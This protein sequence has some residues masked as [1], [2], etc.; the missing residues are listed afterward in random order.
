MAEMAEMAELQ[1]ENA[2]LH[3]RLA[4]LEHLIA[5]RGPAEMAPHPSCAPALPLSAPP[6]PP[7]PETEALEQRIEER[8]ATLQQAMVQ[9][10]HELERREAVEWALRE[11]EERHRIIS[12]LISDYVYAGCRT[13]DG[14]LVLEWVSGAFERIT[15]YT[16]EEVN[17][18]GSWTTLL[19][20]DDLPRIAMVAQAI[21]EKRSC[22][23]EYRVN[24]RHCGIRWLR[25]Y[26]RPVPSIS[27][28][29]HYRI[30]GAVQDI[31][32]AKQTEEALRKARDAAETA[33]RLKSEFLANMSHEI[34]TPLNA[35]IG[36]TTL[37]FNTS[38]TDRQREFVE[39]IRTGGN[40]LLVIINNILDY[41]KIEAGKLELDRQPLNLRACLEE[42]LDLIAAGAAE[43]G[44][45]LTLMIAPHIPPIIM[46][47][48][49]RL[50]QILVNLLSNA[51][52]FTDQGEIVVL[53]E[54][55]TV[56]PASPSDLPRVEVHIAVQD[57][58]IGIPEEQL[59]RLFQPFTQVDASTTRKHGGTGLG[60]AISKQL[61]EMMGG[62]MWVTSKVSQGSTFHV[63]LTTEAVP[64]GQATADCHYLRRNQPH[65]ASKRVLLV[66]D[67]PNMCLVLSQQLCAWGM[68]CWIAASGQE[69]V[70]LFEQQ[71]DYDLVLLDLH[72]PAE[73]AELEGLALARAI[74]TYPTGQ[75]VPLVLL[76]VV[77]LWDE[78]LA[79]D[80]VGVAAVLT[81]PVKTVHLYEALM[82]IFLPSS[83]PVEPSEAQLQMSARMGEHCPL[84]ILL[85]ED[86]MVN[87][88]VAAY[89]LEHMGYRA[90]LATTG[91][92]AV[93]AVE[94]RSY[95]V[96]LMDVQM[97]EMDG[98]EATR[99]IRAN[100]ASHRQ[101]WIIAMT[102][103]AMRGDREWC[104]AAGMND[105]IS[106]PVQVKEL[107]GALLRAAQSRLPVTSDGDSDTRT[108][109]D[110]P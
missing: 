93:E 35:I 38:L 45:D 90:D 60:L 21:Q 64:E 47:D 61:A 49:T 87:Q 109:P 100:L 86:N 69:A 81:M 3:Q 41:S 16:M 27:H 18:L 70:A 36:M 31:T 11:N 9:L 82:T 67:N 43:K 26:I 79:V 48:A 62:A 13:L 55:R 97:P 57:T 40:A 10:K 104:L 85:V 37:L 95:D 96:V 102:A 44:L 53:V 78:S 84:N 12:E 65:L 50:R 5:S 1:A 15:G 6:P 94:R 68:H 39:T 17:A 25:D 89:L 56:P 2:R 34:R 103:H 28:Q 46:G 73:P 30:I 72:G 19:C 105:Y 110:G 76:T 107:G 80:D 42:S 108:E 32:E 91:L 20:P 59:L 99:C 51:V 52:K 29:C 8:T 71:Q 66:N 14:R 75:Q 77:G 4:E 106:K 54:S 33:A 92:E 88:K 22:V 23:V 101:P 63:T 98:I 83:T 58:G 74:R 24:T 7:Q